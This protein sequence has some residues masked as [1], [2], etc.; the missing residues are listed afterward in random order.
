MEPTPDTLIYEKDPRNPR[1]ARITR[2]LGFDDEA[3][4]TL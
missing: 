4:R 2:L 3:P 1:I